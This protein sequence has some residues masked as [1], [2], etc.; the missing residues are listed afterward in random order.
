L[1]KA[2]VETHQTAFLRAAYRIRRMVLCK[3]HRLL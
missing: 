2:W 1:F 3:T